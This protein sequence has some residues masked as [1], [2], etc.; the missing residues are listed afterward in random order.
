MNKKIKIGQIGCGYWGPNLV[1][2]FLNNKQ[3][4]N[5]I[6][7]DSN[8]EMLRKISAKYP[9]I[10][11]TDISD[12]IINDLSIDAVIIALPAKLHYE[13][14][15]KAILAG[16]H[17]LVEKPFAMNSFEANDLIKIGKEKNKVVMAGHTFIYNAAVKK[18]KKIIDSGE[19]GEIYYIFSQRLN[20]GR[21]RQDVNAMWNLAPHDIS[22]VLYWLN[23]KPSKVY[24]NGKSFLQKNIEDLVFLHLD[25]PSGKSV[26]I[27]VSWLDP[28]KTRKMII[29]ASKK[30]LIYDDVSTEAKIMI[31]DKGIDKTL[32]DDIKHEIY[33][34]ASFQ[35]QTRIGDILIPQ[36]DFD[37]PLKEET[38]HFIDCI[39]NGKLPITGGKEGLEVV[40]ILE[41]AQKYL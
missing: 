22:I 34:F 6:V 28:C 11:T 31:Y 41:K 8:K 16:K 25:F 26:H 12:T 24:A 40:E 5:I 9:S 35:L 23:E 18:I 3:V 2:N 37:E 7:C 10:E 19:L 29:V 20:L 30:M 21:V 14:A 4:E 17:V 15:K 13:Y 38:N 27:H 1:R 39:M 33:D 36:I 32:K